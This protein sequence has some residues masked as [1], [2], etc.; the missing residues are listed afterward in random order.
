MTPQDIIQTLM[1]VGWTQVEIAREIGL[2][3]PSVNRIAKGKHGCR[4]QYWAA[5]Q[6]LLD[7]PPPMARSKE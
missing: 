5:M 2:S 6:K 1:M 3:Q 4:W 7:Q